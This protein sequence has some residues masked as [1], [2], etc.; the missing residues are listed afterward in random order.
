MDTKELRLKEQEINDRLNLEI[1]RLRK[2]YCDANNPYKIGD[3]FTD[4]IGSIKIEKIK[5][6]FYPFGGSTPCCIYFGVELLKNGTPNKRGNKRM[7]W[8]SNEIK[9]Q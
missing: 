7:A 2:Q 1:T 5:Y 9:N 6:D 4:H 8:Q 3:T